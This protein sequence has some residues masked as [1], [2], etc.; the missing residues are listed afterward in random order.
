MNAIVRDIGKDAAAES[1]YGVL[2]DPTTLT[3]RRRISGPIERVWAYLTDSDLRRRW[4]ASGQM[5][6]KVGAMFDLTWRNDE[7]TTPPGQRP[8]GF[9]GVHTNENQ[10]LA[11]EPNRRLT[12]AFSTYGE[13]TFELEPQGRDVLLTLIHSGITDRGLLLIVAPSWHNHLDLLVDHLADR[14]PDEPYWD[15]MSR[16][17]ADYERRMPA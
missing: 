10:L 5:E 16:L 2:T 7:L 6:M 4:L 17:R 8:E 3:L 15:K 1:A 14:T 11:V 13:V 12:F 9:P